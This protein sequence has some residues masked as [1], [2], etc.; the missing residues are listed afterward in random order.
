MNIE[1]LTDKIIMD[2][3]VLIYLLHHIQSVNVFYKDIVRNNAN[4]IVNLLAYDEMNDYVISDKLTVLDGAENRR[5]FNQEKVRYY[6]NKEKFWDPIGGVYD[7]LLTTGKLLDFNLG[8]VDLVKPDE[9][10]SA[11][12]VGML[13]IYKRNVNMINSI[14]NVYK[15]TN[16][17]TDVYNYLKTNSMTYK[18]DGLCPDIDNTLYND[19]VKLDKDTS[20]FKSYKINDDVVFTN[21]DTTEDNLKDDIDIIKYSGLSYQHPTEPINLSIGESTIILQNKLGDIAV[22]EVSNGNYNQIDI[23][24]LSYDDNYEYKLIF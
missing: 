17:L 14:L 21:M 10:G 4:R 22:F 9:L 11:V 7:Y 20:C 16:D 13:T 6:I 12:R 24:K 1:E 15:F 8:K 18:N 5:L 2:R 19:Y 23:K 3:D